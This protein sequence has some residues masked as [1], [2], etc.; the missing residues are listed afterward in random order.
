MKRLVPAMA[1]LAAT[2]G[3][4]ISAGAAYADAP[5]GETVTIAPPPASGIEI[6]PDVGAWS[7]TSI[8]GFQSYVHVEIETSAPNF[9]PA[10]GGSGSAP[11][12]LT[13]HSPSPYVTITHPTSGREGDPNAQCTGE[14]S[15]GPVTCTYTDAPTT[16]GQGSNVKRDEFWIKV[17]SDARPGVIPVYVWGT[18]DGKDAGVQCYRI[19]LEA[20]TPPTPTPTPAPISTPAPASTTGSSGS[21]TASGPGLPDTGHPA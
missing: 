16:P 7:V 10:P 18:A 1:A 6:E 9:Q 11:V 13:V 3:L 21:A 20:V 4:L 5:A 19:N 2:A 15:N 17:S 8:P 12:T 14:G